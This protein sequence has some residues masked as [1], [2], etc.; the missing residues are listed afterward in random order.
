VFRIEDGIYDAIEGWMALE[1]N[2]NEWWIEKEDEGFHLLLLMFIVW[3]NNWLYEI[4]K[5]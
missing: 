3:R 1:E 5:T 2:S 4:L